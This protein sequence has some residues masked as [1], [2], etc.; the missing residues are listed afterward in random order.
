MPKNNK[1]KDE[2]VNLTSRMCNNAKMN[3]NCSTDIKPFYFQRIIDDL[4]KA[5]DIKVKDY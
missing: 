5:V 1:N 3:K 4:E 2:F